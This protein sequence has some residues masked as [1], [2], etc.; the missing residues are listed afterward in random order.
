MALLEIRNLCFGYPQHSVFEDFDFSIF[1]GETI[2]LMGPNGAG[3]T[4]LLRLIV[5]LIKPQRGEI[6]YKN[7]ICREEKDFRF[8]RREVGL[9]FQ[10]PDDQLFCPTVAEDIA[11]GP[12]NLG[13]PREKIP[14]LVKET[15]DI[16]GLSGFEERVTYRLSGGEKR[17]VALGTVLAM[18][19][20]VLLL[21]EPTG[22]LDPRNIERLSKILNKLSAA[23]VVVSH[24]LSFLKTIAEK[25][26]WL[27]DGKLSLYYD[28]SSY[29]SS[30]LISL[31]RSIFH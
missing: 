6:I 2:G 10:D 20:K 16:L 30:R 8:L 23:K 1:P 31:D 25:I 28:V 7:R 14:G 19:P 12:L 4:T 5:G 13:V 18:K 29:D 11:F 26:Y 15:L 3:K 17:L 24:D 22:D 9:V 27:E 21:D